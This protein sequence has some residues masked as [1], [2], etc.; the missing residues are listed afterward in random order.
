MLCIIYDIF[1]YWFDRGRIVSNS[2]LS[3]VGRG[4]GVHA[5]VRIM[6]DEVKGRAS[7]NTALVPVTIQPERG[8]I[9]YSRRDAK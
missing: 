1:L 3:A 5:L 4:G 6:T 8:G 7:N 9:F 2:V